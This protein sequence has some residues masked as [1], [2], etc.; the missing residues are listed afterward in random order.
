[1]DCHFGGKWR[2]FVGVVSGGDLHG[3][4]GTESEE[5]CVSVCERVRV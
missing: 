2:Q 1:M 4:F 5:E 3:M